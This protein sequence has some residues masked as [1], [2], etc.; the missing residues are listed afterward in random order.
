MF[1]GLSC[2]ACAFAFASVLLALPVVG[3]GV[4]PAAFAFESAACEPVVGAGASLVLA[5][6]S[7]PVVEEG[8]APLC[9]AADGSVSARA[10]AT[11]ANITTS[12]TTD[13]TISRRH[14]TGKR[15]RAVRAI[16][17]LRPGT[18]AHLRF[19]HFS[20]PQ[21]ADATPLAAS[22]Q[23]AKTRMRSPRTTRLASDKPPLVTVLPC[24]RVAFTP[25][26]CGVHT[27]SGSARLG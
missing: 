10:C 26:L 1:D 3:A 8:G 18:I 15:A 16:T 13:A 4:S 17:T 11:A 9:G 14:P 19:V 7:V 22:V 20:T 25:S 23:Y 5:V 27:N 2:P 12:A 6:V 24:L 21:E